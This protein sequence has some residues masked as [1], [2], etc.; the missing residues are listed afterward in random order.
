MIYISKTIRD[1]DYKIKAQLKLQC[2]FIRKAGNGTDAFI[3]IEFEF[4]R[5]DVIESR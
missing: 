1:V 5:F 4:F 2:M 3:V